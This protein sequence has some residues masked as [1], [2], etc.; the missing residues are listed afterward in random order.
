VV[1][2]SRRWSS[3]GQTLQTWLLDVP[4]VVGAVFSERE[5]DRKV[6][7]VGKNKSHFGKLGAC[8]ALKFGK[9]I[10]F[11][12]ICLPDAE[13]ALSDALKSLLRSV[14][15]LCDPANPAYSRLHSPQC[16]SEINLNKTNGFEQDS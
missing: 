14:A 3:Y 8:H 6:V 16:V 10:F 1:V 7:L 4:P 5:R 15:Y 9:T 11:T 12:K 2:Q 13:V